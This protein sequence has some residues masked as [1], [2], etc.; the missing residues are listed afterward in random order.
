MMKLTS[1]MTSSNFLLRNFTSQQS[2]KCSRPIQVCSSGEVCQ[3]IDDLA[4]DLQLRHQ[5]PSIREVVENEP[6]FYMKE[7]LEKRIL[8]IIRSHNV[9]VKFWPDLASCHYAKDTMNWYE[10]NQVDAI[11][12]TMNPPNCPQ[13]RQIEQFWQSSKENSRKVLDQRHMPNRCCRNGTFTP[14]KCRRNW[15]KS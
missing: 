13:L 11:P 3:K 15:F 5:K 4:G 7:C 2:R 12:K 8:P 6:S 10:T 14:E 9:S 1:K